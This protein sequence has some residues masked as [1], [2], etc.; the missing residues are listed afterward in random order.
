MK[1]DALKKGPLYNYV[2]V[3]VAM[4]VLTLLL[5]FASALTALERAVSALQSN[6]E[7]IDEIRADTFWTLAAG[8]TVISVG[9]VYIGCRLAAD[10]RRRTR[11]EI[12]G[13]ISELRRAQEALRKSR[14]RYRELA[15]SLPQAVFETDSG[16]TLTFANQVAHELFGYT[17]EDLERGTS[18]LQ[19]MAPKDRA[20]A[21]HNFRRRLNGEALG[22]YEYE[23]LRSDGTTFPAIVY[24][25]AIVHDGQVTGFRGTVAD[26]TERKDDERRLQERLLIE[27]A[28]S[29]ASAILVSDSGSDLDS[30]VAAIGETL[31]V[32]RV[33]IMRLDDDARFVDSLHTWCAEPTASRWTD[34]LQQV[35][36]SE[37]RWWRERLL[38]GE[39]VVIPDIDALADAAE[40]DAEVMR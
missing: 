17:K 24:A 12:A 11:S 40:A 19:M 3:L 4:M 16:G 10:T 30:V 27:K 9:L 20:R 22:N 6:A 35:G 5:L 21:R 14:E 25:D 2:I 15:D 28:V 18:G 32:S 38:A 29:R 7:T 36:L 8:T 23:M 31:S 33:Y 39:D 26:I 1:P 37:L 13:D 34:R